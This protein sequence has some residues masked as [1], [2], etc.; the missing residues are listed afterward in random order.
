MALVQS[1]IIVLDS[2]ARDAGSTV[3]SAK[4][5]LLNLG[6]VEGT[7]E[8]IGYQSANQLYNV[9][10]GV[11]DTVYW[12]DAAGPFSA[13]IPPGNY[14]QSTLNAAVKVVMD[15]AGATVYTFVINADTS[16]VTVSATADF[17]WEFGT[18]TGASIRF[19]LGLEEADTGTAA[20]HES[21]FVPNLRLHTHIFADIP[22]DGTKDVTRIDGTQYTFMI[23]LN[24]SF[25]DAINA[26]KLV[27]YQQ[28][29]SF[30]N[31]ISIIDVNLF[32]ETGVALVNTPRYVMSLR[33]QF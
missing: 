6:G 2:D 30:T 23:P 3:Q 31:P 32:S 14:N 16:L 22:Q 29:A 12:D 8:L 25:G 33:R 17:N 20:S 9:E 28:N 24:E 18:S 19:M 26:R 11:N 10:L 4:Y 27:N 5:T 1:D 13:V 21:D 7:Y 15:L